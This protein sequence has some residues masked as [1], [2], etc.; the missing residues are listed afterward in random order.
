MFGL[1]GLGCL[2]ALAL[3]GV[4]EPRGWG[5]LALESVC[6]SPGGWGAWVH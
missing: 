2:G 3:E 6:L 5:A 1:R 4:F